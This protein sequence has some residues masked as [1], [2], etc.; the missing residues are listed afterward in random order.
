[1]EVELNVTWSGYLRGHLISKVSAQPEQ[2]DNVG[3]LQV[4][5]IKE[6]QLMEP[7]AYAFF[8]AAAAL[9]YKVSPESYVV[10]TLMMFQKALKTW[11]FSQ[12]LKYK[13][14][15]FFLQESPMIP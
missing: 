6:C 15:L 10:A 7:R 8:L 12:V 3:A 11:L 4:S 2:A 5:S 14:L 1:M 13:A 9:R